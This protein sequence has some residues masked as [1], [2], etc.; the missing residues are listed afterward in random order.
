[1]NGFY[2]LIK[3]SG[4]SSSDLVVCLRG[5]LRK[6]TGQKIKVGHLGTLDP[7]ASGLLGVAVGSATKLFDYFLSKTK[8]Y[9][10]TVVLGKQTDTLDLGGKILSEKE[11]LGVSD[12]DFVEATKPFVGTILQMPPQYSAK[13]VGGV[14]AYKLAQKGK[15]AA[16]EPCKI[17]IHSIEFLGKEAPEIFKIKIRCSGGTYIRSLCRDIGE[18]LGYPALMGSLERLENGDFSISDAVTLPDVEKNLNAGFT[19]LE[20]F[21]DKLKRIDFSEEFAKKLD[22]GVKIPIEEPNS[23]VSVYLADRFYAIGQIVDGELKIV[24]RDL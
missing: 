3:P 1:M 9:V 4:W 15:D 21:G 11:Y 13:S 14:R 5:L 20:R 16:L 22:N 6:R 8:T 19:S 17:T 18:K 10:A 2:N 7:L 23:F 24:A 12:E